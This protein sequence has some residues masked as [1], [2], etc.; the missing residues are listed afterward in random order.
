VKRIGG[1]GKAVGCCCGRVGA[2]AAII[3]WMR[4]SSCSCRCKYL[5]YNVHK[6]LVSVQD[7]VPQCWNR[8]RGTVLLL[9]RTGAEL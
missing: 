3:L 7:F 6:A 2:M 1:G 8:S 5:Q 4:C 9:V